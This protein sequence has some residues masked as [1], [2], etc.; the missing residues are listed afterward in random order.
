MESRGR[1]R[2]G[3]QIT[4][5]LLAILALAFFTCVTTIELFGWSFNRALTNPA[6]YTRMIQQTG[7]VAG[8]RVYLAGLLAKIIEE[9][10][11]GQPLFSKVPPEGWQAVAERLLPQPWAEK[12]V[13]GV[14]QEMAAWMQNK[15]QAL[16]EITIDLKP[17]QDNLRSQQEAESILLLAQYLPTC[18]VGE[19]LLDLFKTGQIT[20]IPNGVD[21]APFA[22]LLANS[23]ANLVPSQIVVSSSTQA[24]MLS[25][26]V[27]A[28]IA[29]LHSAYQLIK[30]G[31]SLGVR[32]SFLFLS[33]YGL[34][35]SD[36]LRR[37]LRASPW[38]FYAAGILSIALIFFGSLF[39]RLL[40]SWAFGLI[41]PQGGVDISLI[42]FNGYLSIGGAIGGPWLWWGTGILSIGILLHLLSLKIEPLLKRRRHPAQPEP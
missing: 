39:F 23:I 34:L 16:P 13:S 32:L 20:C 19:G 27:S 9:K 29:K 42:L 6:T 30:P 15:N 14:I 12:T 1:W 37:L 26:A 33:I 3:W 35:V 4:R 40:F 7:L 2:T 25:P 10:A 31:L 8:G 11:Q 18:T 17:V 22:P 28:G 21:L 5:L 41:S 24:D 38:P 36:S